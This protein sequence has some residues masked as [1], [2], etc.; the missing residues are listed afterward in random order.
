MPLSIAKLP[1]YVLHPLVDRVAEKLSAWNGQLM[2]RSGWLTLI[3]TTL[4]A[5]HVHT[6]ISIELPGWLLKALQK[7]TSAFLW[8]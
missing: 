2:H 6:S 8:L 3:K 1:K 5:I 4:C 7:I